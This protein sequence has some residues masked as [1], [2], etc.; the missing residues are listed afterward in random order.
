MFCLQN[1]KLKKQNS[2]YQFERRQ[3]IDEKKK[4]DEKIKKEV[5][6]RENIK[7]TFKQVVGREKE[8]WEKNTVSFSSSKPYLNHNVMFHLA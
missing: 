2:L 1:D 3:V 7:K 8:K 6:K 5:E 4:T